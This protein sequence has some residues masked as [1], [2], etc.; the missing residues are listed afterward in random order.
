ML[1]T[2]YCTSIKLSGI[3]CFCYKKHSLGCGKVFYYILMVSAIRG[4][5]S[6]VKE[7]MSTV[8]RFLQFVKFVV[9][10]FD[11]AIES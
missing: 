6:Y 8:K 4:N 10:R 3:D 7:H 9:E 5:L 1:F 11:L 2:K